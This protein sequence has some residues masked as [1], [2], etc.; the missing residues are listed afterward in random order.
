MCY[1][2]SW[3]VIDTESGRL[4]M[5]WIV[6]LVVVLLVIVLGVLDSIIDPQHHRLFGKVRVADLLEPEPSRNRSQWQKA[7]NRTIAKHFDFVI[8]KA[9]DLTA[10]IHIKGAEIT[11][12]GHWGVQSHVLFGAHQC[13]VL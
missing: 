1:I 4:S 10:D 2:G 11:P 7:F 13:A 6:P 5:E 3:H 8:C 12:A 9:D